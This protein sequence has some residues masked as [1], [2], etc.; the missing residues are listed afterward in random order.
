MNSENW[1][2][3]ICKKHD[4]DKW[5][6]GNETIDES[7]KILSTIDNESKNNIIDYLT[8]IVIKKGY[9]YA[10]ASAVLVDFNNDSSLDKI[11]QTALDLK[12]NYLEN[13]KDY[14]YLLR[15]ISA[16]VKDDRLTIV[17]DYIFGSNFN[18]NQQL[19]HWSLW[20]KNKDL[21]CKA[22]THYFENEKKW[23]ECAI[24]SAFMRHS[25]A[26]S[27][28]KHY[29]LKNKKTKI[30][31]ILKS[32]LQKELHKD[33]WDKTDKEKI[34]KITNKNYPQHL[35]KFMLTFKLNTN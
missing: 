33:L 6:G 16:N 18:S 23:T 28:L 24:V 31:E 12:D 7:K 26:L 1:W 19:I 4:S 2:V 21:F 20:P 11:Y 9:R 34:R 30:W 8:D 22:Y 3:D 15:I 17:S 14:I 27:E 10:L 29:L 5:S 13:E 32:D 35:I 25:D